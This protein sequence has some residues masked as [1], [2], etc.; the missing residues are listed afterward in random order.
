MNP[1]DIT[2]EE[3]FSVIR[4]KLKEMTAHEMDGP[5]RTFSEIME[6]AR[7]EAA[8]RRYK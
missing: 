7:H 6:D 8:E 5:A 3:L 1:A 2:W 4:L